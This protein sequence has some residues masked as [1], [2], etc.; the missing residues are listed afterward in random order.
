[1]MCRSCGTKFCFSCSALLT[2]TYTCQWPKVSRKASW[3]GGCTQNGHNFVDPH[4]GKLV[5]HLKPK[6]NKRR[7]G[8]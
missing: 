3:R 2:E 1:M 4:S 5:K 7:R 8:V 6:A